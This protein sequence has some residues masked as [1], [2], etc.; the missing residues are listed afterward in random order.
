MINLEDAAH[1]Y[2]MEMARQGIPLKS[3]VSLGWSYALAMQAESAKH[4]AKG[5]PLGVDRPPKISCP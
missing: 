2:A 1:D 5:F 3:C 4:K